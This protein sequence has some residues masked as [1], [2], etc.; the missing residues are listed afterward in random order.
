MEISEMGMDIRFVIHLMS[1]DYRTACMVLFQFISTAFSAHKPYS[2]TVDR[3]HH[4]C[5]P[6]NTCTQHFRHMSH[7]HAETHGRTCWSTYLLP[8]NHS[9][10]VITELPQGQTL[11]ST[12]CGRLPPRHISGILQDQDAKKETS[13]LHQ[14]PPPC[15]MWHM[16]LPAMRFQPR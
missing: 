6:H 2:H 1:A 9:N 12:M 15:N 3:H 16:H 14:D 10:D 11:P 4:S 13:E 8:C 5:C 7:I